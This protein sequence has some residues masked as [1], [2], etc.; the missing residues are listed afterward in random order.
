MV[1]F[2]PRPGR[3]QLAQPKPELEG[4][5]DELVAAP[6]FPAELNKED[7]RGILPLAWQWGHWH[8]SSR[9]D[10]SRRSSKSR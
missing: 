8:F 9:W 6:E 1:E 4:P 2:S 10:S 5:Q 7:F 3:I